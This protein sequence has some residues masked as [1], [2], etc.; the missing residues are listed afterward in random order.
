LKHRTRKTTPP[1]YPD[2][3]EASALPQGIGRR[4][5][6]LPSLFMSE[7]RLL[8][9]A[10]LLGFLF[11][12]MTS[13]LLWLNVVR[14]SE[15]RK[16]AAISQHRSQATQVY[17]GRLVD[18]NGV[19]LAQDT[20]VYDLYVHPQNFKE[21]PFEQVVRLLAKHLPEAESELRRKLSL[22]Y[23]TILLASNLE[24]KTV[25]AIK[26]ERLLIP[27]KDEKSG[28][29]ILDK[30]TGQALYDKV[31]IGGLDPFQ[32]P[33][34]RYPQGRLASHVLGYVNDAA[35][36][37]TGVHSRLDALSSRWFLQKRQ[38][39][40]LVDGK[41]RPIEHHPTQIKQF[42]EVAEAQDVQLTI[43]SRLQFIAEREL[44]AG[45][46]TSKA[47]RGALI[48]LKPQTG[49][50]LAL[51][52]FPDFDP[53]QY[54]KA[55][56][57]QLKNWAI[58]DVYEPGSTIKILTVANGIDEGVI[59]PNSKILDT[60]KMKVGGWW[61]HNYDYSKFPHPGNIDLVY[62]LQH[63]SNIASAKIALM[64]DPATYYKRLKRLNFGSTTGLSMTG[65]SK[66]VVEPYQS[67]GVAKHGS[68]GY[69]YGIMA[70]PLQMAMG[71]NA[72]ANK[73]V[74]VPPVL[75]KGVKASTPED[76][77][78]YA[79]ELRQGLKL[80]TP[81]RVYRPE[82]AKAITYLLTQAMNQNKTHPAYLDFI[83][84]AGKT[85]TAKKAKGGNYSSASLVTSFIGY[86]P[87]EAP[88]ILMM[89]V[90]DNP[91]MA[92]SWGST[93]AAPIFRRVA[94]ETIHYL[95]L[96]PKAKI[97][98]PPLEVSSTHKGTTTTDT[99]MTY[100]PIAE[101]EMNRRSPKPNAETSKQSASRAVDVNVPQ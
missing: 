78:R 27:R 33:L 12:A 10:S 21:Q 85:G 90:V 93:V 18:R 47:D 35:E 95:G 17:R 59:Q 30:T 51:A 83:N 39:P 96:V 24:K 97:T 99:H 37:S 74:W 26:A 9:I 36:I 81:H 5:I 92:E 101:P 19:V 43:D 76:S 45:M 11:I 64:M 3:G 87:S 38:T 20:L 28:L 69:G 91:K 31:P 25:D 70:T 63:S 40:L 49:E 7:A 8:M 77:Q 56:F 44:K 29:P 16:K 58:T 73:G 42:V 86:F 65:E 53:E 54:A 1:R 34:R 46:S 66:G 61:I 60:G 71:V 52:A 41:G 100:P 75:I 80:P 84:V 22:P 2:E 79:K 82:T 55:H 62:L 68:M 67:W 98:L 4:K 94:L 6:A 15:Y 48:M 57:E 50:I 32:K 72:I 14:G 13:R 23:S 89:V 88:E